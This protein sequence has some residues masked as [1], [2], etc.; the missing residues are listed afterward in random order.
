MCVDD[1]LMVTPTLASMKRRKED[2][3]NVLKIKDLEEIN[4]YIGI[5]VK[6]NKK[7]KSFV[8]KQTGLI[9]ESIDLMLPEKSNNIPIHPFTD[10]YF[11]SEI[12]NP[13][14]HNLY[15]TVLG[16]LL[17]LAR[18]TRPDISIGVNLLGRQASAPTLGNLETMKKLTGYLMST[19]DLALKISGEDNDKISGMADAD[20]AGDVKDRKSTSG[21]ICFMGKTPISWSATK[22][23]SVAGSTMAAEYM[24][25]SDA[26]K[27]LMY[28]VNLASTITEVCVPAQMFCDNTAAQTIA[29]GKSGPVTKGAKHIDIRYHLIRELV[30]SGKVEVRRIASEL[31]TADIFTKPLPVDSFGRHLDSLNLVQDYDN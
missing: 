31:N 20:W 13:I 29:E 11:T 6:R 21:Y 17:Y 8:M 1:L 23:K 25:L 7:D 14:K 15:R 5:H 30:A 10:M 22:Q 3:S 26:S 16:L 27:E 12:L 28:L 4:E 19:K 24:S 9:Q 2:L 18:V